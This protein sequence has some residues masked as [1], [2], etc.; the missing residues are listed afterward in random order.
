[1]GFGGVVVF[2]RVTRSEAIPR[3]MYALGK[4]GRNHTISTSG[5]LGFS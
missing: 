2:V 4:E 3:E 1:M 5:S